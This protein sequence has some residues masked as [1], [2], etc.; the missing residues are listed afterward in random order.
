MGGKVWQSKH[1]KW[2]GGFP[3]ALVLSRGKILKEEKFKREVRAGRYWIDLANEIYVG[4]EVDGEKW[5]RDVV[6]QFDRDSYLYMRG[7]RIHHISAIRL[8]LEPNKVQQE[9]LSF[10]YK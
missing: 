6:A 4:L 5:H 1:I 7:W 10:L 8:W 9:V 3:L 2:P